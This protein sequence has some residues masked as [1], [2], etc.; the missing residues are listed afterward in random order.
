VIGPFPVIFSRERR[1]KKKK[2]ESPEAKKT[3]KREREAQG[4]DWKGPGGA[5]LE[6]T[7]RNNSSEQFAT[8][9]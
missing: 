8:L 6:K 7:S 1:I 4:K 3:E 5:I 9:G 2:N